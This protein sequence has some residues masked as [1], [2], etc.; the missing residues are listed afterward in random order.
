[1]RTKTSEPLFEKVTGLIIVSTV[2]LHQCE[3]A[4]QMQT[5]RS[6][7]GQQLNPKQTGR[8]DPFDRKKFYLYGL[9]LL[10]TYGNIFRTGQHNFV[11][12]GFKVT[13]ARFFAWDSISRV[14]YLLILCAWDH[15]T[16]YGGLRSIV[17]SDWESEDSE[18]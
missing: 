6:C 3:W 13:R 18:Y 14:Y 4:P 15:Q 9:S 12:L 17:R 16:K 11:V 5:S 8:L 1:M 2:T 7:G 10:R